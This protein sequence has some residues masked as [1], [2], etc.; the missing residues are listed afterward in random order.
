MQHNMTLGDKTASTA[1]SI[2]GGRWPDKPAS[3]FSAPKFQ[4]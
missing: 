3:A 1:C 4:L 2:D